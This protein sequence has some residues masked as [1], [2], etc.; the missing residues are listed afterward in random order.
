MKPPNKL[1]NDSL[2]AG[3]QETDRRKSWAPKGSKIWFIHMRAREKKMSD[4]KTV[5]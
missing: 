4:R 1:T 3:I 2:G 5:I